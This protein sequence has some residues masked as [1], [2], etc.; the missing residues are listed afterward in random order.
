M[1]VIDL[2]CQDVFLEAVNQLQLQVIESSHSWD[3]VVGIPTGG[4]IIVDHMQVLSENIPFCYIMKQRDSTKVK[5]SLRVSKLLPYLPRA[6][7]NLLR[8][9]E[10]SYLE[11]KYESQKEKIIDKTRHP[12]ILEHQVKTLIR[13]SRKVLIIDDAI[14]S[15]ATMATVVNTI[16]Q[17][18]NHAH[19]SIACINT[20]FK[21]PLVEPD[22]CLY[23]RTIV[24]YPWA[25]DVK[26]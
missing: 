3:L 19:I 9:F 11:Y 8:K 15:G 16:K 18:N 14:D 17:L 22:F 24:R 21:A 12:I 6:I 2:D 13:D 4:K 23:R 25:N 10:S 26:R 7:N 5:K 20:T 1:K